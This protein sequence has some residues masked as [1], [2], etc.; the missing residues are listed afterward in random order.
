MDCNWGNDTDA[1]PN[2]A[3]LED[4]FGNIIQA[5]VALAGVAL[6]VMLIIGGFKYLMSAGDAKA[7]ESAR[8]TIFWAIIG[9]VI[10][11][12]SY[13]VLVAIETFTGVKLT[14]FDLFP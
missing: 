9:I 13:A 1:P 8:N 4:L 7:T 11:I 10:M 12:S 14:E 6:F 3:C 2:L 5:F